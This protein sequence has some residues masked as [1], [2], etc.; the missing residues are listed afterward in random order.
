MMGLEVFDASGK[1]TQYV[2]TQ[3]SRLVLR[4]TATGK[5]SRVVPELGQGRPYA[6]GISTVEGNDVES[7]YARVWITNTTTV[8]WEATKGETINIVCGIY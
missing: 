4:F 3:L 1:R 2:S 7:G 6:F 8:N 5:G